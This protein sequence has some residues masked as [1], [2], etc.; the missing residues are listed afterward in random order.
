[1]TVRR[2]IL[3]TGASGFIGQHLV[4]ALA[5]AGYAVRAAARQPVVFDD[6]NIEGVAVGDMSRAFAADF[7]MR[8]VDAVVHAAGTAH[9][10]AQISDDAYAAINV[11]ATRQLAR[12][13]RAA[14]V[15]R[16]V[17]IS[18][19]RA[20][21]GASHQGILTEDLLPAPTDA[22]GR[23][24]LAAEAA[25]AEV[26]GGSGTRWTAL[27][28]VLVYGPNVKGN[29]AALVRLARSPAPMPF[30]LVRSRRSLLSIA[31]LV[32][33]IGHVLDERVA[34]DGAYIAADET[35]V[36]VGEIV[37]ALRRGAGRRPLQVPVP[38]SALTAALRLTGRAEV[39]E[40]ITGELVA[41]AGRLRATGWRPVEHTADALV[42]LAR[43]TA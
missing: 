2:R 5:R 21:S 29:M 18:S 7:L 32:S 22:Y 33:A 39:A 36:T 38:Q 4:P 30:G 6:P 24:K 37:A 12:A 43:E 41:D 42:R 27:R 23:S 28:P 1:M 25:T 17:L 9:I 8:D 3:V 26:L 34:G 10:S 31:N 13:A 15:R 40:R 11:G 16:F 20:Q 14:R 35:P 19:I